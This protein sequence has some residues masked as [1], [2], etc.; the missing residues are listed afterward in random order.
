MAPNTIATE[1]GSL[2]GTRRIG[3]SVVS[4]RSQSRNRSTPAPSSWY[5]HSSA[6]IRIAGRAAKP[7]QASRRFSPI[8]SAKRIDAAISLG[9]P[10]SALTVAPR[11]R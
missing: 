3:P 11:R 5:D 10:A 4:A 6:P 8:R 7:W 1:E 2:R 9:W